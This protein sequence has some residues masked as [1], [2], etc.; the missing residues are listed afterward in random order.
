MKFQIKNFSLVLF[1]L[2]LNFSF[3]QNLKI[4]YYEPFEN[5][6]FTNNWQIQEQ[7]SSRIEIENFYDFY[8]NSLVITVEG[9][10]HPSMKVTTDGRTRSEIAL[11]NH[12]IKN[13][14][15]YYY[16]WD[17]FLPADQVFTKNLFSSE[18]NY[19]VIMQWHE[20]GE[21]IPTYCLKGDDIRKVRAFPV[22]LRLVPG[23]LSQDSKMDLH[24]KY[25]T[26]YGPG[27]SSNDGDIC[28]QDPYSRGYREYIISKAIKIGEWNHIVTQIK[29]STVGDSAFIRMWIN[30]LPIINDRSIEQYKR[31]G[32]NADLRLGSENSQASKLGGV[33][34]L[35]TRVEN[36]IEIIEQNYQKLGHYRKN[37]DS[38]NTILIDNYRITTEYPP[39]PFTTSLIDKFCNKELPPGQEYKLEAYEIAP[40]NYYTFNF[41]DEAKKQINEIKSFSNYIDLTNQDWVRANDKY[42]V[43]VR[44]VNRLNNGSGFDYGRSCK[45]QIP[46]NTNLEDYYSSKSISNPYIMRRNETIYAYPLPGATDYLFKITNTQNPGNEIWIPGNGKDINSLN[47]SRISGTKENATYQISVKAARMEN[48]KDI[49]SHLNTGRS[50]FIKVKKPEKNLDKKVKIELNSSADSFHIQSK[51][52]LK[53]IYLISNTGEVLLKSEVDKKEIILDLSLFK[54][55]LYQITLVDKKGRVFNNAYTK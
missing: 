11:L 44:A 9:N 6:S 48:G 31:K 53:N 12:Q 49:Y 19:Y 32:V 33:P 2:F 3:A 55:D 14:D 1:I 8:S 51:T 22:S 41:K 30:D 50:D 16:S 46:E 43:S 13:N 4:P 15:E 23:S 36:G 26:T 10:D 38:D 39:K 24:L 52:K 54:N 17:I 25:G 29:W 7:E 20:T 18:D 21:G 42:E 34:L 27:N 28:P 47:L 40:S 45:V 35:Y 5:Y 37:Y